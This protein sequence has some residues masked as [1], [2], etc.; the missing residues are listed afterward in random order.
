MSYHWENVVWQSR[1]GLWNRGYFKRISMADSPNAWND[2]DYDSEWDDEFN[3]NEFEA[4]C[5]NVTYEKAVDY[6]PFSN[7]GHFSEVPYKGNSKECKA[8]D[9]MAYHY[10]NPE[11]K[12]KHERKIHNK[13]RRAH[14]AEL[15]RQWKD[16]RLD[17]SS[18]RVNIKHDDTVYDRF[19]AWTTVQG[20]PM[21]VGDWLVIDGRKIRNHKTGKFHNRVGSIQALAF[22]R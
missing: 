17:G 10:H 6:T 1:D 11:E 12:R 20:R 5:T 19:G 14:F 22:P 15:E 8:L 18:L 7:P 9:L 3:G 2:E 21:T 16:E 4:V 13:K